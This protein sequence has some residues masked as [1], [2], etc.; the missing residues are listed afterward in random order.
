MCKLFKWL[1]ISVVLI[2]SGYIYV[3]I[4][5]ADTFDGREYSATDYIHYYFVTPDLFMD[6]PIIPGRITYYS[7]GD[8]NYGFFQNDITWNDIEDVPAAQKIIEKFFISKGYTQRKEGLVWRFYWS[9]VDVPP[10]KCAHKQY[11]TVWGYHAIS[12]ELITATR[13]C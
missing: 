11:S 13:G 4:K 10:D 5:V 8:D 6:P 1:L 7:R 2:L 9:D 3:F 12:I